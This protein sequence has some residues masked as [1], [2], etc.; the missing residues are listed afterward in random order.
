MTKEEAKIEYEI[1]LKD[2]NEKK[3]RIMSEAKKKGT[4]LMGLDSNKGLFVDVDNEAKEK[5]RLLMNQID[6]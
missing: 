1:I 4:W 3:M 6:E 5:I 2:A